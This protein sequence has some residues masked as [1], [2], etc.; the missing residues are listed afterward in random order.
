MPL[1]LFFLEL[2][3]KYIQIWF[4][5]GLALVNLGLTYV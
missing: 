1:N 4:C 2:I 5:L 3:L